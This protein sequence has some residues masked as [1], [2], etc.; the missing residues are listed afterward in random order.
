[1]SKIAND[2]NQYFHATVLVNRPLLD[3]W[4]ALVNV[5]QWHRWDTELK[6]AALSGPFAVAT[7]GTMLPQ[8]GPKLQ[9][10]IS[11]V[12]SHESYTIDTKLPVGALIMK[13]TLRLDST[14][15]F[16]EFHD[17]I[18]FT[19]MFKAPFGFFLGRKFRR[20]LPEVMSNFKQFAENGS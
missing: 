5:E 16:T 10:L 14:S 17:D 11:E 4:Q 9:F 15:G 2:S 1:M 3:V 8:A 19:G 7:K 12:K 6:S 13:R 20:V 18:K